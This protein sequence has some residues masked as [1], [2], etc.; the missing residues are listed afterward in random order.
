MDYFAWQ[1][2]KQGVDGRSA[3]RPRKPDPVLEFDSPPQEQ[4]IEVKELTAST[5]V[6]K[7]LRRFW[8]DKRG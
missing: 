5:T 1:A 8:T 6:I 2:R 4:S 7:R 3:R